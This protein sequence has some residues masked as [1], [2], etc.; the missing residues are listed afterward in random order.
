MPPASKGLAI[1]NWKR[2]ATGS[3]TVS[4]RFAR[5]LDTGGIGQQRFTRSIALSPDGNTLT[6]TLSTQLLDARDNVVLSACGVETG[7]R[8]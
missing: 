1:G 2:T 6:S 5:V 7:A 4:F 3:Y 8:Y